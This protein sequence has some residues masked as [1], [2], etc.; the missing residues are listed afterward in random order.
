MS[1][2]PP[3]LKC[4]CGKILTAKDPCPLVR[5]KRCEI[6][7]PSKKPPVEDMDFG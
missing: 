2:E 4:Q 7:I 3:T 5:G 1:R 6:L